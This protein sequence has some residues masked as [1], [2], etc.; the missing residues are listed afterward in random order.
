MTRFVGNFS[1]QQ[2]LPPWVS[3]RAK[4]W[5]FI[6]KVKRKCLQRYLN[7]H[8]NAAAPDQA[9]FHYEAL[10]YT[11]GLMR[12][13]QHP[14]FSSCH[15]NRPG[16]QTLS[17]I[18]IDWAYPCYRWRVSP[19]N[20]RYDR[21]IVWV[22]PLSFDNNSYTMFS[23]REI[24]G[25]ETNMAHI[26]VDESLTRGKLHIDM[27]IEGLKKFTPKSHSH[28]L[29][30]LHIRVDTETQST[31]MEQ[32]EKD[33][34]L[35]AFAGVLF[36]SVGLQGQ[37]LVTHDSELNTLKQFRDVFNM[38]VAVYR[39]IVQSRSDHENVSDIKIYD[40]SNVKLDFMWSQTMA[41][42]LHRLFGLRKKHAK[43]AERGHPGGTRSIDGHEV[44]WDLP[45]L[46]KDVVLAA[47]F[48]SDIRYDV[49]GTLHTYGN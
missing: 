35:A 5:V 4:S 8:F 15:N 33:R 1:T 9:P 46:N 12:V 44:D 7:T 38:K 2:L 13:T 34:D 40:G 28:L 17:K 32:I 21:K 27:A 23:S 36:A 11:Y 3:L 41:E 16:T 10:N 19:E 49:T 42:S 45:C 39:A 29:G 26:E 25:T 20:I 6:I 31:L 37:S 24:W 14:D 30:C 18:D 22:E 43:T 47:S 48:T